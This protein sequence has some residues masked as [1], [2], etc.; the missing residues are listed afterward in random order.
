LKHASVVLTDPADRGFSRD[1][2]VNSDGEYTLQF[3]PPGSY[4]LTVAQAADTVVMPLAKDEE[5]DVEVRSY[6]DAHM[7]VAVA[8]EDVAGA[9]FAL[10]QSKTVRKDPRFEFEKE[11]DDEK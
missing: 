8:A 1:C 3:V 6:E 10:V 7:S 9:N 5:H 4:L 2:G 11:D